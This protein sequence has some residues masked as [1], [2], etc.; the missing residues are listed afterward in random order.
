MGD[1]KFIQKAINAGGVASTANTAR[2]GSGT[3]VTIVAC[4]ATAG[5]RIDAIQF[6]AAATTTANTL[7]VFLVK[8]SDKRLI[9]EIAVTAVTPSN[10]VAAWSFLWTIDPPLILENGYSLQYAPATAGTYHASV[11]SGGEL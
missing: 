10:T 8:S 6:H 9:K 1:P 3:L 11:I 5:L 2:D 7:K 4:S